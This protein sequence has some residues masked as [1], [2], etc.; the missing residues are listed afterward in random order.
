MQLVGPE[1]SQPAAKRAKE[2][3]REVKRIG[4]SVGPERA[5]RQGREA[6]AAA[7]WYARAM[8]AEA[9]RMFDEMSDWLAQELPSARG[10]ERESAVLEE[11]VRRYVE[12]RKLVDP[13]D[14]YSYVTHFFGADGVGFEAQRT[15]ALKRVSGLTP[16]DTMRLCGALGEI[17]MRLERDSLA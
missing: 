11:A 1:Q 7:L 14:P 5:E 2:K 15:P 8:S 17:A 12:A 3:R 16:D 4:T 6:G 13:D 9:E 10:T